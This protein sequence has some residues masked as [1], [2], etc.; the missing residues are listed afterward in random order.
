MGLGGHMTDRD[1]KELAEVSAT[2]LDSRLNELRSEL[3]RT[4]VT[5]IDRVM[6]DLAQ[7]LESRNT[8]VSEKIFDMIRHGRSVPEQD[9]LDRVLK[10]SRRAAQF[11][12]RD[13]KRSGIAGRLA[14]DSHRRPTHGWKGARPAPM[15]VA[16]RSGMEK[17]Y[18]V[19][20]WERRRDLRGRCKK[21]AARASAP[22]PF[23]VCG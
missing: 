22:P 17:V 19:L 10:M 6:E 13:R 16:S 4:M 5:I 21:S 9:W 7:V 15:A 11:Q 20:S 3:A 12:A 2:V 18:S 1:R 14:A 8:N 23:C